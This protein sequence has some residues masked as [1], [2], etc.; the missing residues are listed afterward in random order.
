MLASSPRDA[1]GRGA[2]VAP[3]G[4]VRGSRRAVPAARSPRAAAAV[5]VAW[6]PGGPLAG[7]RRV[8][9]AR[10]LAASVAGS[11]AALAW[12][13]GRGA[14]RAEGRDVRRDGVLAGEGRERGQD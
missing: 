11:A 3:T 4:S 6:A 9:L 1:F 13:G 12:R 14:A 2:L 7:A 5:P 8:E 10:V